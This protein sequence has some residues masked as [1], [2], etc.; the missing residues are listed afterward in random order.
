MTI[1]TAALAGS[2][3]L[4]I[5]LPM[6]IRWVDEQLGYLVLLIGGAMLALSLHLGIIRFEGGSFLRT[7][8]SGQ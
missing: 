4:L 2:L 6:L 8:I 5:V 3:V 7:L 1:L